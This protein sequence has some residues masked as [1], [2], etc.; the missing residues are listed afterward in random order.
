MILFPEHIGN[1]LTK[2]E[3]LETETPSFYKSKKI[4]K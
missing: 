1:L 3:F 4:I 2:G